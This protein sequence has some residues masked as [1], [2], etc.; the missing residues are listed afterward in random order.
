MVVT[1]GKYEGAAVEALFNFIAKRIELN[2]I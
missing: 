2:S 1:G